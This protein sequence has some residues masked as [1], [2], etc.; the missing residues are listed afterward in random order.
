M[1]AASI[2]GA[3]RDVVSYSPAAYQYGFRCCHLEKSSDFS[4]MES[5]QASRKLLLEHWT[6]VLS[7]LPHEDLFGLLAAFAFGPY[8]VPGENI[9][10]YLARLYFPDGLVV[11]TDFRLGQFVEDFGKCLFMRM[12][13]HDMQPGV[14]AQ[15]AS[16]VERLVGSV[17]MPAGLQEEFVGQWIQGVQNVATWAD[18]R[19]RFDGSQTVPTCSRI[20]GRSYVQRVMHL[21]PC[22]SC[23][24]SVEV[25][26]WAFFAY[27]WSKCS[28]AL[29]PRWV[30]APAT[31]P[32][33]VWVVSAGLAESGSA[34]CRA[35]VV[36]RL[37]QA[38]LR[39]KIP[40]GCSESCTQTQLCPVPACA[41][42]WIG[43]GRGEGATS[44]DSVSVVMHALAVQLR[45]VYDIISASDD[46]F[47]GYLFPALFSELVA[48]MP[49]LRKVKESGLA[50]AVADLVFA[51]WL[52]SRRPNPR[53]FELTF[54][55]DGGSHL[56][57]TCIFLM[58]LLAPLY[59]VQCTS[60]YLLEAFRSGSYGRV[61]HL[62]PKTKLRYRFGFLADS[63]SW[64]ADDN[65]Q[66]SLLELARPLCNC[67]T[68]G[69]LVTHV[70]GQYLE[71]ARG[72]DRWSA[73]REAWVGTCV[74][75][76][77]CVYDAY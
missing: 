55:E 73:L 45:F 62:N 61:S 74:R 58:G 65:E 27:Q 34:V 28:L 63:G 46:Y 38:V 10:V 2:L 75:F 42:A 32:T 14:V 22:C 30:P 7:C 23:W 20:I 11:P 33:F 41:Q 54:E 51:A 59:Q 5:F 76:C 18:G 9:E 4:R 66:R 68:V 43:G 37:A 69:A 19:V 16:Y 1:E 12:F 49:A 24:E 13:H 21:T 52:S 6:Y 8:G 44:T 70:R 60:S 31:V 35:A 64:T 53:R 67:D 15:L 29:V 56:M 47:D 48:C 77:V 57:T 25:D 39:R 71:V 36:L 40:F 50:D 3:V 26:S 72:Y 17:R